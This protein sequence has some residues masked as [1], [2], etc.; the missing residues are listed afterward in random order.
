MKLGGLKPCKGAVKRRKRIGCG[1]GSGHGKTCGRG[2]KGQKAHSKGPKAGFEG[3][4]MPL[5]RRIPKRGFTNIFRKEYSVVN[6]ERLN[7]FPDG[8]EAGVREMLKAGLVKTADLPVK[9]L[10]GGEIKKSL[11]VKADSFTGAAVKKVE[12]AGGKALKC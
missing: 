11:T 8:S 10:A 1:S 9:I 2:T 6:V 4:Q 12:S 3:G 7:V 5:V